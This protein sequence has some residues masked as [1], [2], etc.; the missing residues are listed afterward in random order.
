M[1]LFSAGFHSSAF[2]YSLARCKLHC[3]LR[4]SK[5]MFLHN[6]SQLRFR[7]YFKFQPNVQ[8]CDLLTYPMLPRL[9]ACTACNLGMTSAAI[10]A[11]LPRVLWQQAVTEDNSKTTCCIALYANIVHACTASMENSPSTLSHGTR[12]AVLP[13]K[14]LQQ[15]H[16]RDAGKAQSLEQCS[17]SS[18]S[19]TCHNVLCQL[20]ECMPSHFTNCIPASAA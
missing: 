8:Y 5:P 1:P 3:T 6:S 7:V 11:F 13:V 15:R 10:P 20:P 4:H 9:P 18:T 12:F 17:G 16:R 19:A 14:N 2:S